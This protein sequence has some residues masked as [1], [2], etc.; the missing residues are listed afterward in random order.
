[1]EFSKELREKYREEFK[2]KTDHEIT[3]GEAD[4]G[5]DNLVALFEIL[6]EMH[7]EDVLRKR[8]LK[9]EPDGYALDNNYSCTVCGN[10]I[11]STNGWYSK[12]GATCFPCKRALDDGTVPAFVPHQR[13]SYFKSWNLKD[14]FKITHPMMKKHIKEGKLKARLILSDNGRVHEY[15]FLKKENLGLI[16]RKSPARKSYD[17]KKRKLHKRDVKESTKR[18]VAEYREDRAKIRNKYKR[19]EHPNITY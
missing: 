18:L 6:W 4:E 9:K 16:D 1:M 19:K 13:D 17:R 2:D 10:S 11:N 3:D 8:R 12:H 7:R 5:M 15:I 14:T